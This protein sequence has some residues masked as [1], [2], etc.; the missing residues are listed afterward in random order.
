MRNDGDA[1]SARQ[2]AMLSYII[3]IC[4]TTEQQ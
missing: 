2:M 1:N 4:V 3:M